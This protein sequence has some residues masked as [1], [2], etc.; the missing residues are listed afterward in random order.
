MIGSADDTK[1]TQTKL[2]C[3]GQRKKHTTTD[4]K[5]PSVNPDAEV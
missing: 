3:T 1:A 5:I 2:R 4:R